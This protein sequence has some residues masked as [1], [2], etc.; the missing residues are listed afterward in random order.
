[1]KLQDSKNIHFIGIGGIGTSSLAQILLNKEKTISGSDITRS[2][3]TNQLEKSGIEVHIG[4]NKE[5]VNSSHE[6]VIHSP[7]IPSTNPELEKAKLLNIKTL[8]YPEALGELTEEYYTIAVAG[9]HGKSTT[10]AMTSL[11]L[12]K[13][14][15]DPTVIIGTKVKQFNNLNFRIGKSEKLVVEACEYKRS[16]LS[17]NPDILVITNIEAD[18]LDYYKD[19]EDYESAFIELIKRVPRDGY[20]IINRD[21]KRLKALAEHANAEI[22]E[23]SDHDTNRIEL[24]LQVAG[25]FNQENARNAATVGKVLN[26]PDEDI[27]EALESFTGTWRRMDHK[28]VAGYKTTFIDDYAHHP[29]EIELTLNAIREKYPD[30]KILTIFQPHQYSRTKMLLEEFGGAFIQADKVVIPNI[31]EVRDSE[32]DIKKVNVDDLVNE[33]KKHKVDAAN[34]EGLEKTAEFVKET[35]KEWDIIITMGAGDITN[36][37]KLF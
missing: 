37:Y 25:N 28:E 35:H 5:N 11:I 17:I 34:G 14:N 32:E 30:K 19:L 6:L 20:V 31:Y 9:T 7:A 29:T 21:N 13:N 2:S 15:L 12:E 23:W 18:H 8:T 33:I 24:N 3:I 16:F 4:H 26:I 27:K 1:M 10:T 36:I 22:I